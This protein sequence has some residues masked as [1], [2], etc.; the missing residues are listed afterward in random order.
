MAQVRSKRLC[1]RVQVT[2]SQVTLFTADPGETVL[3]KSI[4][5]S[6]PHATLPVT[7]YIGRPSPGPAGS[8]L[9]VVTVG[10]GQVEWR[11][12]WFVL[13]PSNPLNATAVGNTVAR[14]SVFG[15]E[16]EGVAD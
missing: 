8:N 2:A 14:V 5:V 1:D 9:E 6:N 11:E 4:A 12:H 16:L 15:A 3:V 10:P 13:Q 7:V